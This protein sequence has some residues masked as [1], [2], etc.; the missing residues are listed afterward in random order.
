MTTTV[1]LGIMATTLAL[2]GAIGQA[3]FALTQ[4]AN[5]LNDNTNDQTNTQTS[6]QTAN[7]ATIAA[8]VN[9][10]SAT[11]DNSGGSG[12]DNYNWIESG[13]GGG[14]N[15]G[16]N[17]GVVSQNAHQHADASTQQDQSSVQKAANLNANVQGNK[18]KQTA[19]CAVIND[20]SSSGPIL[21]TEPV[22]TPI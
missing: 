1:F 10:P 17:I 3:A 12:G 9:L 15:N 19:V 4:T 2:A 21:V 8:N 22:P 14:D 20:C 6:T 13:N 5:P 11:I 7:A 18:V 16:L